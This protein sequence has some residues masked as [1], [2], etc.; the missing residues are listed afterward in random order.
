[1]FTKMAAAIAVLAAMIALCT[2]LPASAGSPLPPNFT[3]GGGPTS[4]AAPALSGTGQPGNTLSVSTGG[5][6]DCSGV[7][8]TVTGY[9]WSGPHGSGSN[10]AVQSDDVGRSIYA[11]VYVRDSQGETNQANS[12]SITITAPSGGGGGGGDTSSPTTPS[13]LR[14]STVSTSS[15]SLAWTASSDNVSVAGY[16]LYKNG[17][18]AGT[19]AATSAAFSSLSCGTSYTMAVDAYDAAGNRSAKASITAYTSSCVGSAPADTDHDGI[20]DSVDNCRT[21]ANHDQADDD[22]DN[23]GTACDLDEPAVPGSFTFSEAAFS[24][25]SSA[26]N[27]IGI[28]ALI[29]CKTQYVNQ[30]WDQAGIKKMIVEQVQFK[31]CYRPNAGIL[32]VSSLHGDATYAGFPW[33]WNGTD[34]GY[35]YYRIQG[36]GHQVYFKMQGAAQ[37]N[38]IGIGVGPTKHLWFS[39][40]FND[41]NTIG[42]YSAGT[43]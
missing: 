28:I 32:S 23:V 36:N 2:A 12:N 18:G 22:H 3:C 19:T 43:V 10:Y 30:E 31:V 34:S 37:I 15:I 14:V 11:T 35:P 24:A 1:M 42:G 41:N 5:W 20:A 25:V 6:Q 17:A 7:S 8:V 21:V 29:R 40:I 39:F 38:L 4:Y 27:M 13:S 9:A 16:D 26:D 33:Q